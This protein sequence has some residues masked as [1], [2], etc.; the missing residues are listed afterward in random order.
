[1]SMKTLVNAVAVASVGLATLIPLASAASARDGHRHG[2]PRIEH[3]DS[4]PRVNRWGDVR[5]GWRGGDNHGYRRHRDHTGRN[6]A[7]GAFAAVLGLALAA[8]SQRVQE[9]YYD[10]RD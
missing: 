2:G 8:E 7:I 9:E 10:D 3:Y 6:V 1:M 4:S 5:G